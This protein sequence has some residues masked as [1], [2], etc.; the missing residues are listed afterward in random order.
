MLRGVPLRWGMRLACL[1]YF[2][3]VKDSCAA[4]LQEDDC[5]TGLVPSG[6]FP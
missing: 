1:S 4:F 3:C 2:M 5:G 6:I